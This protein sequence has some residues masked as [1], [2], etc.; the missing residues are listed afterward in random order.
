MF[1]QNVGGIDK[2]LRITL[3]IAGILLGLYIENY[4]LTGIGAVVLLTGLI[5]RCLLYYPFGINTCPTQKSDK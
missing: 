2:F 4:V 5:G 3:G 1:K